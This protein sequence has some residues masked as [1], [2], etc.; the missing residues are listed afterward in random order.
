MYFLSSVDYW[1]R[2]LIF[3]RMHVLSMYY[4]GSFFELITN[5]DTEGVQ[6]LSIL[7]FSK[8]ADSCMF[9]YTKYLYTLHIVHP[10]TGNLSVILQL[11]STF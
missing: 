2:P 4:S 5:I 6:I 7:F 11:P 9:D 1:S 8:I 3:R 10:C